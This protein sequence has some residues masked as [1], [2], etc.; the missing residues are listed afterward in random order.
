ML[1]ASSAFLPDGPAVGRTAF[2]PDSTRPLVML[3]FACFEL[4]LSAFLTTRACRFL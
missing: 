3:P 2:I 1:P 4:G